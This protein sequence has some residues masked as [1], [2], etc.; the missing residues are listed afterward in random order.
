M[1]RRA[2]AGWT[3]AGVVE[4]PVD[5]VW[6]AL[7]AVG[8][9]AALV[10]TSAVARAGASEV[11]RT[12]VGQP[13]A[14]R[15]HLEIDPRQHRIALQG[16]WWYRGVHTVEPHPRGS[17]VVYRVYNIAPG[18]G[19]WAAQL[20]QGPQHARTMQAQHRELLQTLGARLGC[21]AVLLAE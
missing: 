15:T 18:V 11:L 19:R 12:T 21:A 5:E 17:R 13:G 10:D 16:D 4:A 1:S 3:V 14:G 20:V 8:P 7:L 9:V 2:Q 6:A